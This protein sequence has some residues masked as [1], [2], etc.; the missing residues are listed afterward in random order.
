MS[1]SYLNLY[2]LENIYVE[3]VIVNS[4]KQNNKNRGKE[5]IP[6]RMYADVVRSKIENKNEKSK[7]HNNERYSHYIYVNPT[8]TDK[9]VNYSWYRVNSILLPILTNIS[10]ALYLLLSVELN[11]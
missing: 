9:I 5:V 3:N 7:Q 6:A 10:Q 2:S 1:C 8:S 11:L 4:N